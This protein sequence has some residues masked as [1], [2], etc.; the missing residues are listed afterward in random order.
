MTVLVLLYRRATEYGRPHH[1]T[2]NMPDDVIGYG[3]MGGFILLALI[4]YSHYK[5]RKKRK[6][7]SFRYNNDRYYNNNSKNDITDLYN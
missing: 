3:A 4:L 1:T 5:E 7:K 2:D 6:F